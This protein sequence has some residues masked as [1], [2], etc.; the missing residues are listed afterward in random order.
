MVN[1]IS[2]DKLQK[3]GQTLHVINLNNSSKENLNTLLEYINNHKK[4]ID[5]YIIQSGAILF[6]GF[7]I[8]SNEDFLKIK[9][10]IAGN[11]NF[12]YVDGNSP[13]TKISDAI[14]T[15][16]EY[17]QE[18]RIPLHS[19]MSYS[20]KWPALLF[21]FCMTPS[22][23]GGET[24]IADCRVILNQLGSDI[25]SG[26]EE[27]GVKYTRYLNGSGRFGKSWMDTFQSSDKAT[28]EKFCEENKIK[29]LWDNDALLLSQ[30]GVGVAKHPVTHEKVWFNQAN[31]F[32]PSSLPVDIY[33]GLKM[34][35]SHHKHKFPQYAFYGNGE[36]ICDEHIKIITEVHF[37]CALKF[38]WEK[39][40]LLVLDNMLM[41]HGRM[42]F[43]G[44]RK[45]F[46][47]M[48]G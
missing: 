46:I 20:H 34:L 30:I 19:E 1:D 24:P 43:S 18:Y 17:P 5:D 26:F 29:F 13:R 28:V 36:D 41:S 23:E 16:T 40:D 27:L 10:K 37:D 3:L 45:I 47:S 15:S 22:A 4:Q 42:P 7:E 25:V 48:S 14:Y 33:K 32:H 39:G 35:Y 2:I 11:L 8:Y 38:K 21:F 9:E 31:Q 12:S 44:E 6:R